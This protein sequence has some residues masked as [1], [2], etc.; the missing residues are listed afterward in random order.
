MTGSLVGKVVFI[1][2][3]ARGIGAETARQL[4]A[5]GARLALVGLEPE[6]L[7]TLAGELGA[8]HTGVECDGTDQAALDRAAAAARRT[9]GAIDVVVAN[10][11]IASIGTVAST[12]I[13]ALVRVIDVNLT[14]VLRTVHATLP[15]VAARRGYIAIVSSA[16]AFAA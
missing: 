2:G 8:G 3:P 7:A 11:G 12:P 4:A 15:D 5:R 10:A 16:A 14:G 1:T 9:F 6:R 13:A